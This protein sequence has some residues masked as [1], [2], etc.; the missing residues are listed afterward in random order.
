M[1]EKEILTAKKINEHLS[2]DE[3][4]FYL[5]SEITQIILKNK[6]ISTELAPYLKISSLWH[7]NKD[8]IDI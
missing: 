7:F 5:P 6:L 4:K 2:I 8:L 1:K 3:H